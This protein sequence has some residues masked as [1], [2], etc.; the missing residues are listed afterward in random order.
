MEVVMGDYGHVT[1][2]SG[3]RAGRESQAMA[4]WG[5]ALDF[6]EKSKANG[7]ID[8]YETQLFQPTGSAL[9]TGIITLWGTDDQI[10]AIARNEERTRLQVRAG[11]ILDHLVETRSVR[12]A[13]VL[14]GIGTFQEA[15]DA[16]R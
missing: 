12:G 2:W 7:L 5:D 16:L 6:Y 3:I 14:E 8:E 11:L 13:A 10:D 15:I 9:P 1:A 4:L